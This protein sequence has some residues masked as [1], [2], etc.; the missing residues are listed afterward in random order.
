MNIRRFHY[1][2]VLL[3]FLSC[4][5]R[6]YAQEK[7]DVVKVACIGNSITY[8]SGVD[9]RERDSYPAVLG[10]LLDKGYEVRNYGMY[11]AE[12]EC[13]TT[14]VQVGILAAVNQKPAE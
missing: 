13:R 2:C 3:L 11:S 9:N 7:Q 4:A 8:G 14:Y 12:D 5:I 1:F 10:Q 6:G